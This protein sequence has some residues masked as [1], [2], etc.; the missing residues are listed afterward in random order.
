MGKGKSVFDAFYYTTYCCGTGV[1][2]ALWGL[3]GQIDQ[4]PDGSDDDNIRFHG[5]GNPDTIKLEP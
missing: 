2:T 5:Y 1:A 3:N 4:L